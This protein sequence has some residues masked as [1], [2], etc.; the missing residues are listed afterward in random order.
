MAVTS[1]RITAG[2]FTRH[3]RCSTPYSSVTS[4]SA[5]PAPSNRICSTLAAGSEYSMKIWPKWA[6]VALSR[7]SRSLLGLERVCSCRKT[8]WSAYSCSLPRA[9]NPRRSL[10]SLDARHLESLRVGKD[11]G[12][13]LLDQNALLAPCAE[14]P[15]RAGVDTFVSLRIEEFRQPQDDAHQV[16]RASL[17][18][19]LLHGRRNFVIRLRNHLV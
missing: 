7:F 3:T 13:F 1:S 2:S 19:G 18:I 16:V 4:A 6:R 5:G 9:M 12:G 8:T 15:G 10:I 11:A 17:I 14:V